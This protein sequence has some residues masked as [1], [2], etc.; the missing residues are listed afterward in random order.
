MQTQMS[1]KVGV[2]S[3]TVV[4]PRNGVML[5]SRSVMFGSSVTPWTV[6]CQAS[7]SISF[8]RQEYWNGLPFPPPG[9]L[10]H[11]GMEPESPALHG[12]T[13]EASLEYYSGRKK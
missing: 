13:R 11:P 9:N 5:F 3:R 7:L 1:I 6:A 8:S 10:L 4:H 12:A 2:D